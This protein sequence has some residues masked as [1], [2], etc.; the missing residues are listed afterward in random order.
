MS[1]QDFRSYNTG[2]LDNIRAMTDRGARHMSVEDLL[3]L[4][5]NEALARKRH[6][7][8]PRA[9]HGDDTRV[10][11]VYDRKAAEMARN[12]AAW[13]QLDEPIRNGTIDPV[14]LTLE[15]HPHF[16]DMD[17][18]EAEEHMNRQAACQREG[19][20][21]AFGHEVVAHFEKTGVSY[22]E[23]DQHLKD[24][25][26]PQQLKAST[27]IHPKSG[28]PVEVGLERRLARPPEGRDEGPA[29][30]DVTDYGP[31]ESRHMF[32]KPAGREP[33]RHVY[34]GVST[35]E[36]KQARERGY[37]QSDQRGT[38]GDWEGT[39]AGDDPRTAVSYLPRG[40]TGH[41]LK[42]RVHPDD[43]WF[44]YRHDSY[45]RTRHPV[46]LDRVEAVSPPITKDDKFGHITHIGV[47]EAAVTKETGAEVPHPR[48]DEDLRAHLEEH[49]RLLP[50]ELDG[51]DHW[52]LHHEEHSGGWEDPEHSHESF[53]HGT[54][55]GH[56]DDEDPPERIVPQEGGHLYPGEHT[57]EHAFATTS[58]S[59]AWD[60]AEKAWSAGRG[61]QPRVLRVRPTGPFEEDPQYSDNGI[62]RSPGAGS[63]RSR[64]PWAFTGREE[65]IP[66]HLR[67]HDDFRDEW[68]EHEAAKAE[69]LESSHLKEASVSRFAAM[70]NPHDQGHEWYHGSPY[71][72]G[73]F[74]SDGPNSALAYEADENDTSHWNTL[75]GHHFAA[76]HG[77]AEEFS[78]GEHG[79]GEEYGYE[80]GGPAQNVI[81][82]RLEL[83]NP[84]VYHS[85]HDMDQEVYE[86]E[87][88]AGNHHDQYHDEADLT[89]SP[90]DSDLDFLPRTYRYAGHSDRMRPQSEGDPE[91][92]AMGHYHPYA[93]SWLN[94]HPD[95][96]G[97]AQRFR[98]RLEEQGH[99]GIVYGNEFE[100]HND[101]ADNHHVCAIPFREG[102]IDVTQR[103]SGPGCVDPESARRQWPGRSQPELPFGEHGAAVVAHFEDDS[104]HLPDGS[105][106]VEG[107]ECPGCGQHVTRYKG[108]WW[109]GD[110]TPHDC[111]DFLGEDV[112]TAAVVAHFEDDDD[113]DFEDAYEPEEESY[114]RIR[115]EQDEHGYE[116][117][118]RRGMESGVEERVPD[119]PPR[120]LTCQEHGRGETW[121][122]PEDGHAPGVQER[123]DRREQHERDL[124]EGRYDRTRYCDAA[125]QRSHE[126]DQAHGI[127]VHHT[128]AEGEPEHE[129]VRPREEM[130]Q[131]SGPYDEPV[132]RPSGRYEVRSPSAEHRCHYC[133]N[134]LPQ[135][136][137]QAARGIEV[138]ASR[139]H[140]DMTEPG[141]RLHLKDEHGI[142]NPGEDPASVHWDEHSGDVQR[143][144][145]PDLEREFTRAMNQSGPQ[146][147]EFVY[148]PDDET[149]DPV[150]GSKQ[151]A[152]LVLH[153][154]ERGPVQ[155]DRAHDTVLAP[156][157]ML[158]PVIQ[159]ARDLGARQ[160]QS[161]AEATA[162]AREFGEVLAALR[163]GVRR[164]ARLLEDLPLDPDVADGLHGMAASLN[165]MAAEAEEAARRLPPEASWEEP[166][167][168]PNR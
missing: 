156:A 110:D 53:Y 54:S 131:L 5:S 46:P 93:T 138:V 109:N 158:E 160:P 144:V 146:G 28:W 134:I 11:T 148:S 122:W 88:K 92:A 15:E 94:A 24:W 100:K 114:R 69:H 121:H 159:A 39:N 66:E 102:Q 127:S 104:F 130:P 6:F 33:V 154:G 71:K 38:I 78:K 123:V 151:G 26:S 72:F 126:E 111:D 96:Y 129:E 35:D 167:A 136:R 62:L 162:T 63:V 140:W 48:T 79:Y 1:Q 105:A 3:G 87:F 135:Y 116:W 124:D 103:H 139:N 59:S 47:K 97:I 74:G 149:R 49:H 95:K 60:Y 137:R 9:E 163:D 12:P 14:L 113:D 65:E 77:M 112:H 75:L 25:F 118:M 10:S 85:E 41:V 40:G 120:C 141:M 80:G 119:E 99:D 117:P 76:S 22:E 29:E 68:S 150:F 16:A 55:L 43:G 86:H 107:R 7:T 90:E 32:G 142:V 70:D 98:Q 56:P 143:H 8:D 61:Q 89:G 31:A 166:P 45:L 128:F 13:G 19:D 145:H 50:E 18:D 57:G 81:H 84:K 101:T 30:F 20:E 37:I 91:Y 23:L 21:R 27:V 168:S 132:G 52:E 67:M 73:D 115:G 44:T 64:H 83:R 161:A 108:A 4:H 125:C 34:R 2:F 17:E 152:A 42:I 153:F 133:R 82:A 106:L 147:D 164:A 36:W 58:P 155:L 51:Q 165:S 157:G